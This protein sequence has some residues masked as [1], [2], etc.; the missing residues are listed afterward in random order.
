M[1]QLSDTLRQTC[2]TNP[3]SAGSR[4]GTLRPQLM[5]SRFV[6]LRF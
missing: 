4:F 1:D 5:P 2:N 3:A 6:D